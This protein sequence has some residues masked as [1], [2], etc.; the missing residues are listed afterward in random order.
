VNHRDEEATARLISS[1]VGLSEQEVDNALETSE[2]EALVSRGI[3]TERLRRIFSWERCPVWQ[4]G[5][6]PEERDPP[7]RDPRPNGFRYFSITEIEEVLRRGN[8]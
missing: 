4:E 1:L 3:S 2:Q 7:W 5:S 8:Y 6:P